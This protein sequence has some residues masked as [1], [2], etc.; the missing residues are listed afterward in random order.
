M[1]VGDF[2]NDIEA[3]QP[4]SAPD[5]PVL[6]RQFYSRGLSNERRED[7]QSKQ[8]EGSGRNRRRTAEYKNDEGSAGG[9]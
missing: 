8:G 2:L 4:E 7:A 9:A 3:V 1:A 6:A 5:T